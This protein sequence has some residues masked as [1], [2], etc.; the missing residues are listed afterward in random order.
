MS[1]ATALDPDLIRCYEER[2]YTVVAG[3]FSRSETDRLGAHF[4]AMRQSQLAAG[5]L[6]VGDDITDIEDPLAV[7]PRIL[8]PHR[9]DAESRDWLLDARLR[10][11]LN[12]LTG[13]DPYAVQTMFYFKPPGARGQALHQDQYHLRVQPGTCIA[14]WM[15]VD[16]CDR[17]TGCLQV[18]PRT[19]DVPVLCTEPA[20]HHVSFSTVTVPLPPHLAPEDAIMEPGDVLFFNGQVIHGS[21]P[22]RSRTRFRRA[23]IAHYIAGEA[24]E[25]A[26]YYFPVLDMDGREVPLEEAADGGPCGVWVDRNGRPA[27]EP[28][29]PT[30]ARAAP[31]APGVQISPD[32]R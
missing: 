8:Q 11:W 29:R 22:N 25:V 26:R 4:E 30:T 21:L 9:H 18:V 12:A 14:A 7:Y 10:T 23:L 31:P 17:E 1:L 28:Q 3:L 27:V 5:T 6:H 32:Q 13:R 15:A 2:G 16:R 19:S 20:D 24:R